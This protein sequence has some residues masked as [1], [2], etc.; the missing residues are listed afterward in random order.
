MHVQSFDSM[1]QM[2]A[3]MATAEDAANAGLHPVQISLRDGTDAPAYWV[4]PT[5]E[6]GL[7][8]GC[9]W[10]WRQQVASAVKYVPGYDDESA[11]AFAEARTS[12]EDAVAE[13][14]K[15]E[16]EAS[17][18]TK[19]SV[20]EAIYSIEATA[21]ARSR[22]YMLGTAHSAP[23]PEAELGYTHVANAFPIS[24]EAFR[25]A[26]R[27]GWRAVEADAMVPAEELATRTTPT[28][29]AELRALQSD[30]G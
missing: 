20:Q 5:R 7:I 18:E 12:V 21:D 19:E 11:R 3:A 25:E 2:Q 9:C 15:A 22:G 8:F 6:V 10:S 28:L 29:I 16:A 27:C 13:L 23:Y 4:H 30:L 26:E 17:G 24:E 14:R 1:E